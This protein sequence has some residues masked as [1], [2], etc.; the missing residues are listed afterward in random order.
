MAT[1][2][3]FRLGYIAVN[4]VNE[5]SDT[6]ISAYLG[7]HKVYPLISLENAVVT[8]ASTTYNGSN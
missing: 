8:C 3:N 7:T 2:S 1:R 4:Y 5:G 6:D